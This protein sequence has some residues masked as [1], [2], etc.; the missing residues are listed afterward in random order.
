MSHALFLWAKFK[1][2]KHRLRKFTSSPWD[3]WPFLPARPL[4]SYIP[5]LPFSSYPSFSPFIASALVH[6]PNIFSSVFF[7]IHL[8]PSYVS[9]IFIT[10]RAF[11]WLRSN[12]TTRILSYG[13]WG[14]SKVE[15][16][17]CIFQTHPRS[18]LKMISNPKNIFKNI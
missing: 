3:R 6:T 17:E 18:I 7:Y 10:L 16:M 11:L 8:P 12:T 4:K 15:K 14:M 5:I 9:I 13:K 1:I 2:S